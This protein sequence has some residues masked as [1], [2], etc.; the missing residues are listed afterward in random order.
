MLAC[1]SDQT[2]AGAISHLQMRLV[3]QVGLM[4]LGPV[5]GVG[6]A[7]LAPAAAQVRGHALAA[8]KDLYRGR[9]GADFYQL[10]SDRV[11][12]QVLVNGALTNVNAPGDLPH[13]LRR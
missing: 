9:G 2:Q 10:S 8:M 7:M 1:Q 13:R 6:D 3:V 5:A 11:A 12:G 4:A